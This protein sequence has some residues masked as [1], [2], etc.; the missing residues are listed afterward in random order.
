MSNFIIY[1]PTEFQKPD[2]EDSEFLSQEEEFC[3]PQSYFAKEES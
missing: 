1:F 2:D 3:L